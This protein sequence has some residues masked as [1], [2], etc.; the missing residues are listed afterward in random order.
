MDCSERVEPLHYNI[1]RD[2]ALY[3]TSTTN[4]F[5]MRL[6]MVSLTLTGLKRCTTTAFPLRLTGVV[7]RTPIDVTF[8]YQ[9]DFEDETHGWLLKK[10][11]SGWQ[12]V[13]EPTLT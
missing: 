4:N 13:P 10:D 7:A 3:Q 11:P 5:T 8:P 2:D 6:L 1:Y 9:E 12:W